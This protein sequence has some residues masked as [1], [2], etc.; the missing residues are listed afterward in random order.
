[1]RT[2]VAHAS[3]QRRRRAACA[4]P[5]GNRPTR[6]WLN[7]RSLL[8]EQNVEVERKNQERARPSRAS[9]RSGGARAHLALQVGVPCEP[10]ARAAQPRHSILMLASSSR[11][12]RRQPVV[13]AGRVRHDHPRRRYRPA[14]PSSATS[15]TCPRSN[16]ARSTVECEDLLFTTCARPSSAISPLGR[17]T[18][19]GVHGGLR[20]HLERGDHHRLQAPAAGIE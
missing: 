16:P 1:M 19:A 18:P 12:R 9:R 6:S 3:Q 15:S 14:Q 17:R 4:R 7:E 10:V 5:T 8:A 11:K 13:P 2:E 20:R